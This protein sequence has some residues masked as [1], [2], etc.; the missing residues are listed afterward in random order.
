MA[1]Y[2]QLPNGAVEDTENG[3]SIPEDMNNSDYKEYMEWLVEG[4]EPDPLAPDPEPT[5]DELLDGSDASMVR[6][7]DWMLDFFI[8][9]GT[10]K[11]TEIPSE[12]KD[13]YLAR[14]SYFDQLG[15]IY[16]EESKLKK[17]WKIL[18]S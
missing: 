11:D 16:T 13:L 6:T 10:I 14:K 3:K 1:K 7:V 2:K 4:N 18:T 12:L 9:K 8:T 17:I 5:A 15:G